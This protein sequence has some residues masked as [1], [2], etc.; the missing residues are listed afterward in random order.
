MGGGPE[1][2]EDWTGDWRTIW[3]SE[4]AALAV[5]REAHEAVSRLAGQWAAPPPPPAG[6]APPD[7][8]PPD[9]VPGADASARPPAAAAAPGPS[10][11]AGM[12]GVIG[13]LGRRVA[14]LERRLAGP[15]RP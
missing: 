9:A 4:L 12:A 15:S 5:D 6:A 7:A 13:E 1:R 11:A 8:A 2:A 3:Q 14:E 10:V